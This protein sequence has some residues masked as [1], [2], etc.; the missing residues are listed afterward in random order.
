[1]R[2][3]VHA[4]THKTATT[5]FQDICHRN[6]ALL[7]KHGIHYPEWERRK[8]HGFLAYSL[9]NG[10]LDHIVR[11]MAGAVRRMSGSDTLLIS[12]EGLERCFVDVKMAFDLEDAARRAGLDRTEWI[13]VAREPFDYFDSLYGELSRQHMAM[14]YVIMAETILAH[15]FLSAASRY[16]DYMFVFD[17]RKYFTEFP[18]Y[19]GAPLHVLPFDRFT[20]PYPGRTILEELLGAPPLKDLLDW[21]AD[22]RPN[23]RLSA[24]QIEFRYVCNFL[25][26]H[27]DQTDRGR[28][29]A[30]FDSAIAARLAQIDAAR[31]DIQ[32]RFA[33]RFGG[34]PWRGLL[35]S[36]RGARG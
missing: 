8:N 22:A 24:E 33:K 23:A 2:L 28:D 36:L 26:R 1:M 19:R 3:V 14:N 9:R 15:G 10:D 11:L 31:D 34:G 7:A 12:G 20:R 21:P 32:R 17:G 4:G 13:V 29:P 35:D 25:G 18:R 30:L 5:A 6:R 27:P 16:Y